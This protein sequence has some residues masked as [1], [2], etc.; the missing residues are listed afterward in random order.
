M[1]LE[2]NQQAF[3]NPTFINNVY[4]YIM[5]RFYYNCI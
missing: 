1:W 2:I 3:I 5:N 4:T